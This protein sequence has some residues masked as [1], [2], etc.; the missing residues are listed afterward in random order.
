MP[1]A[2]E[3][4]EQLVVDPLQ[5]LQGKE[6]AWQIPPD[7]ELACTVPSGQVLAQLVPFK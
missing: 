6:Q 1:F 2:C 5:V 4:V 7:V 3:Q